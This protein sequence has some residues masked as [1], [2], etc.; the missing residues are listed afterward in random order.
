MCC[1]LGQIQH[2]A[3]HVSQLQPLSALPY[4]ALPC[5]QGT[6]KSATIRSLLGQEQPAGYRETSRV[7]QPSITCWAGPAIC[8]H[9]GQ[10][11]MAATRSQNASH[12][13]CSSG[14]R[15]ASPAS[16]CS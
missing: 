7:R 9:G 8:L 10:P 3:E 13:C 11:R 1:S 4:T 2:D 12:C 16:N 6:G 14:E 5:A 15:T